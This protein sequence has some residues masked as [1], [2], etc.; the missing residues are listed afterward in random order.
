MK[1]RHFLLT[2]TLFIVFSLCFSLQGKSQIKVIADGRL[3]TI[4]ER[5]IE[6]NE[7]SRTLQGYRIKVNS[8]TGTNAKAKAFALKDELINTYPNTRAY[9]SFD[10]PNFIV[11]CGDFV[12]RLDAYNLFKHIKPQISSAIIIRDWINNPIISEADIE[13]PEY[14]EENLET[15]F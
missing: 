14:F 10:E 15:D 7:M 9:V 6:Y 5:H 12:T 8:F 1:T 11:K 3:Q 2:S 13:I 4:L